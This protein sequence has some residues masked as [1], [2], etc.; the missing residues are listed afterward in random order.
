MRIRQTRQRRRT[1]VGIAVVVAFCEPWGATVPTALA[2]QH[3]R[4]AGEPHK[5]AGHR[6]VFTTWAFVRPGQLD[7]QDASGKSVYAG[8]AKLGPTEARFATIDSPR[9]V[10]LVAEPARRIGPILAAEK[11]WEAMGVSAGILLHEDGKYRL[12]GGGQDAE[13][14]RYACYFESADGRN[15]QRPNLGL[16]EFNGSRE[17]NL[18]LGGGSVFKDPT[19]PTEER[20]KA[21]WHGD[22]PPKRF[23]EYKQRRP[24]SVPATQFDPGRVHSIR[25]AVSPDGLRWTELADSISVEPSDTHI[26]AY[27]DAQLG[28]YVMYTR[29]YMVGPRA[30][31]F[32]EPMARRSEFVAR[33]AIGRSE[34]ANFR[35]FPLSEV[36]IEPGNDMPP[37]DTCYTNCRT[38]IPGAWD[39]HLMFP[40]IYHQ[41]DDT[42]SVV[43]FTS[44]DGKVWHS[45]PGPAVLKTADFGQWDGGCVFAVPSLVEL[46]NGDWALAYT[47]YAYP[48]KYPR[49]SWRYGVGLAVWP[50]GRLVALAADEIGEFTTTAFLAPGTRL[51]INAVTARAGSIQIEAAD[52]AGKPIP[53]RSFDDALPIVGDHFW[54]PVTWKNAADLGVQKGEPIEFR[55]RLK[56]ARIYGVQ[57]N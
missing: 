7:W 6:L 57:F 20:Y 8:D 45:M 53:G 46:A 50:K 34:T 22:F 39:L 14:K 30:E 9:G 25:A 24:W 21:V 42:T 10:R 27:Y 38:S 35:E 56:M 54:T 4:L 43:L 41:A 48:H 32:T 18:L 37:T 19:A 11:P 52:L 55:F 3:D 15:W 28:K 13:G 1:G 16:V 51:R 47:G 23:E 2:L 29:N 40:A 33:R 36:V 26:V 5:L 17:N 12:W 31:E 44:L 49:G